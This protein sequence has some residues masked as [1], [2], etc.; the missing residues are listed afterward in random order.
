MS[1]VGIPSVM[2]KIV[3]TPEP[4]ASRME[5]GAPTA[6]T[7]MHEVLA[8]VSRTAS[9]IVSNTGTRLSSAWRPPLPG[10]IPA[11]MWVP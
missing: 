2:Q 6:G 1:R 10:V 3:E 4:T 11:T 5:S 7:K 8:P 9:S